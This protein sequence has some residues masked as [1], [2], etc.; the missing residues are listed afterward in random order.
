MTNENNQIQ[1]Q[2][3]RNSSKFLERKVEVVKDFI[4]AL[5]NKQN[6]IQHSVK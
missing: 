5:K 2:D 1:G 3:H 6:K 4:R